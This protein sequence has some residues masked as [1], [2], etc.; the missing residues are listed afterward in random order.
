M[1]TP[2][3]TQ[4]WTRFKDQVRLVDNLYRAGAITSGA[5]FVSNQATAQLTAI[6][7]RAGD[8]NVRISSARQNVSNAVSQLMQSMVSTIL[9]FGKLIGSPSSQLIDIARDIYNDMASSLDGGPYYVGTRTFTRGSASLDTGSVGTGTFVPL[10]V[11][12][13]GRAIED[14]IGYDT[15]TFDLWWECM[16]DVRDG[17]PRGGEPFVGYV[18]TQ[19]A[20]SGPGTEIDQLV[21]A[22]RGQY[23]CRAFSPD[24]VQA[25]QNAV[26]DSYDASATNKYPG[27][28]SSDWTKIS[29]S[30]AAAYRPIRSKSI[31]IRT[32]DT[33]SSAAFTATTGDIYQYVR[34]VNMNAPWL[35]GFWF[36]DASTTAD[37]KMKLTLG[38]QTSLSATVSTSW[39]FVHIGTTTPKYCWPDNWN[40]NSA[41]FKI[42]RDG[43]TATT[44]T[45]LVSGIV[46]V[47]FDYMLGRFF[48][49]LAGPVDYVR[50]R[51][52]ATPVGD[53]WKAQDSVGTVG[54]NQYWFN[55]VTGL[56]LPTSTG[57]QITDPS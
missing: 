48:K 50:Y 39:Q 6:G 4:L 12:W 22:P 3:R 21:E 25:I 57:T 10:N 37:G 20:D 7:D 33:N 56:W 29:N 41:V 35:A 16:A 51:R 23:P 38:G 52:N 42:E 55:R 19:D 18:G 5:N 30:T 31:P 15:Q 36:K 1:A 9:D 13:A 47:P 14:G 34:S 44:G 49:I 43:A 2:T 27:W 28:L 45:V 17:Q 8:Q 24:D 46:F 26:L 11:D 32:S 53:R 54:K 40:A